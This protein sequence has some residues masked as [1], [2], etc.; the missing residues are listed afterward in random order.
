VDAYG[1]LFIADYGNNRVRKVDTNGIITTVAGSGSLTSSGDGGPATNAG[2]NYISAVALDVSNN[3]LIAEMDAGKVR[4]VD[5]N[6]NISTVAGSGA[7]GNSGDGGAAT[8]A[9]MYLVTGIAEDA[10]GNLFIAD[11]GS[12]NIR[13]VNVNGI[14]STLA[15]VNSQGVAT[16]S[17]G[18]VYIADGGGNVYR[19]DTQSNLTTLATGFNS[20]D[21]VAISW[22]NSIFIAD[23]GNEQV[24]QVD[25]NGNVS[26][27][28]GKRTITYYG[29]GGLATNAGIG[30]YSI[31]TDAAGNLFI[32][33]LDNCRIRKV[34]LA[35]SPNLTLT[36]VT[37]SQA[38]L[39]YSPP[40]N[41]AYLSLNGTN[42]ASAGNFSVV[43]TS[44][45]GSVTSSIASLIVLVPPSITNQPANIA[46]TNGG[47]AGFNV[48]AYGTAP[49]SYQWF[50]S[51]GR[52]ATA[53]PVMGVFSVSSVKLLEGGAG[54]VSV[55]NV[56]FI[57]NFGSGASATAVVTNGSVTGF[58]RNPGGYYTYPNA[59]TILIDN[60][61]G[62]SNQ[63]LIGQTNGALNLSAVTSVNTTNY[64]VVITNNYGSVTSSMAGLWVFV[65]PQNFSASGNASTNGNQLSLQLAGTPGYPYI[66]Q[67]ATNLMP[68]VNWQSVLTNLADTYGNW[69]FTV[70]NLSAAPN[71]YYRAVVQ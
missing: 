33:D 64:F 28:V 32:A 2:F 9:R 11:T 39:A 27:L 48:G 57:S 35:G 5:A 17:S 68:P 1:N 6:G 59:P 55:P 36:S 42:P 7:S 14:I 31:A 45:Y 3:L 25:T 29:D 63:A 61:T 18:N 10:F 37:P 4:K 44:P 69:S 70:T 47:F 26:L 22:N 38:T 12:H 30:P 43:V 40:T 65:P 71:L 8:N 51:S 20:A 15:S 52:T 62:T 56:Q 16:D 54:Y 24:K 46:V 67:S 41:S 21:G 19:V 66:L 34:N 13:K 23:H 50:T 60:P 49:L 53:E 58:S